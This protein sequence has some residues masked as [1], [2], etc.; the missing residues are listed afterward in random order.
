MN[1][2][3]YN[4][5]NLS[6]IKPYQQMARAIFFF[7]GTPPP[8]PPPSSNSKLQLRKNHVF[9]CR[10]FSNTSSNSKNSR[11]KCSNSETETPPILKVAVSAVAEL[12]RLFSP[13]NQT[14]SLSQDTE[15]ELPDEFPL[16]SVDDA[17]NI[18]RSDYDKA[19]FVT[20]N[21]TYSIYAENC[22]FED[23]TIKFRG[24]ELYARNLKLLV[25]F[26]DCASIRLQ[27]IE[28]EGVT[29]SMSI[30]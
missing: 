22:I 21:F 12:L 9:Q 6:K 29:L 17:L 16:S 26:F 2:D 10:F 1:K 24:R 28:K 18:I 15:E 7:T 3:R 8:L 11:R 30:P 23:P 25:P 19:Y 14:S 20:G 4:R 13:S 27:K 5:I